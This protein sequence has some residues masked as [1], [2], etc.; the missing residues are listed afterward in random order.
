MGGCPPRPKLAK[1]PFQEVRG[2]VSSPT[3]L[4]SSLGQGF[5][6]R[7]FFLRSFVLRYHDL[8][9]PLR[10][11]SGFRV[12]AF[13]PTGIYRKD[14]SLSSDDSK[15]GGG[16]EKSEVLRVFSMT[17]TFC[18]PGKGGGLNSC[19]ILVLVCGGFFRSCLPP[20]HTTLPLKTEV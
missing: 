19:G 15:L 13:K 10:V 2:V 16:S 12:K 14:G 20:S 8:G 9:F 11:L 18:E 4:K 6:G 3:R 17:W 5:S 1:P 7:L